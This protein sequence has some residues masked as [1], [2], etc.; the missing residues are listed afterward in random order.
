MKKFLDKIFSFSNHT[1]DF[2]LPRLCIS[3]QEILQ[4]KQ[5]YLC[6]NCLNS[7]PTVTTERI[8]EEYEKKFLK[9]KFVDEFAAAFIFEKDKALQKVL[10][11]LKYNENFKVGIFIGETIAGLVK[12]IIHGWNP[13][14]IVP[15]PLHRLK[16]AERGFNQSYYIAKG[17]A[18]IISIP[19]KTNVIKRNRFTRTQTELHVDERK[20]NVKNAFKV[21]KVNNVD[22]KKIILL[23]DV[24]T[25]G[26]TISECAK[27]LKE[28][29]A[30]KVYGLSVA[31]A[32]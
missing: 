19:I 3:C 18:N 25:T 27:V 29:G 15:V 13:D 16:K 4:I 6:V 14:F 24:I 12:N 8:N 17:I 32:D 5:R 7:L 26:A 22:N 1:L 11:S 20:E 30:L 31:L 28:N 10:H 2:I 9:E 21:L 23:D